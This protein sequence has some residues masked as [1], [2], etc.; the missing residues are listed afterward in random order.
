VA[1]VWAS[2]RIGCEDASRIVEASAL[3]DTGATLT[4]VPLN[5]A[6]ELGLRFTGK[7]RVETAAGVVEMYRSRA[8]VEIMGKSEIVPVLI[9]DT[10]GKVLISLLCIS[11][12]L[13]GIFRAGDP[14]AKYFIEYYDP[15]FA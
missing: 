11:Q 8:Y 3:V 9:T 14:I 15:G 5:V 2:V 10:I 12:V 4:V 1:R 6:R 7:S 13:F